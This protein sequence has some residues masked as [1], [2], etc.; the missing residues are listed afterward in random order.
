[1]EG[2]R[3]SVRR[4]PPSDL[5][6]RFPGLAELCG[7]VSNAWDYEYGSP[8][9]AV[10]AFASEC[11]EQRA[12]AAAGIAELFRSAATEEE[13]RGLLRPLGFGYA[14]QPGEVDAFLGWTRDLLTRGNP[15]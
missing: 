13:R 5:A 8:Q 1:M 12:S 3:M 6:A 4:V 7:Y 11:P 14:G 9:V 2:S 15:A 10:E